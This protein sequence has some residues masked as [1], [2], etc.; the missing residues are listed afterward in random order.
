M[1]RIKQGLLGLVAAL[2]L[3]GLAV[4]VPASAAQAAPANCSQA[5]A[6]GAGA[7][8]GIVTSTHGQPVQVGSS[9]CASIARINAKSGGWFQL[10]DG[11][12]SLC[13]TVNEAV[14]NQVYWESCSTSSDATYWDSEGSGDYQS[15]ILFNQGITARNLGA[16][17]FRGCLTTPNVLVAEGGVPLGNCHIDWLQ[18]G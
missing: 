17:T 10:E 9:G 11:N 12:D 5:F 6:D 1:N 18:V 16:D 3:A 13:L 7:D 8:L 14:Q 4:A 2:P 15:E